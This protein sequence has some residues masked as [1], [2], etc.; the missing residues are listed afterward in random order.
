MKNNN[1]PFA[2]LN[3]CITSCYSC[4]GLIAT[5]ITEDKLNEILQ[6]ID[7][8]QKEGYSF[9]DAMDSLNASYRK[10]MEE[11]FRMAMLF[12][13]LHSVACSMKIKQYYSQPSCLKTE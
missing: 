7:M 6:C 13:D 10:E 12:F 4:I 2:F 11:V 3:N 1:S 5:T 8:F 9:E